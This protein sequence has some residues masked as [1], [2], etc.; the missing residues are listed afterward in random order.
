MSLWAI[1]ITALFASS[2]TFT[3]TGAG[4]GFT[5][6]QLE[7]RKPIV[8]WCEVGGGLALLPFQQGLITWSVANELTQNEVHR[9]KT[10]RKGVALDEKVAGCRLRRRYFATWRM[11][12]FVVPILY[13]RHMDQAKITAIPRTVRF[14]N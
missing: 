10:E 4:N 3:K 12:S 7:D 11:H 8:E 14:Q 5:L 9:I 13:Q 1:Q 6:R 2:D